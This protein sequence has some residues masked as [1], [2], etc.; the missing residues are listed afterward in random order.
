MGR[1]VAM[2]PTELASLA[3][4]FEVLFIAMGAG[5]FWV[6]LVLVLLV[7][8][9][10]PSVLKYRG[11]KGI[12]NALQ[13]MERAMAASSAEHD[14]RTEEHMTNFREVFEEQRKFYDNNVE[15]VR[16]TQK[17]FEQLAELTKLALDQLSLNAGVMER[18][19]ATMERLNASI[20]AVLRDRG[21]AV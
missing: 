19:T 15:V 4:A 9:V 3:K 21:R 6:G 11:D 1:G 12:R 2:T 5:P 18:N 7:G 10:V 8:I 14:L 13:S 20:E 17:Q 16:V